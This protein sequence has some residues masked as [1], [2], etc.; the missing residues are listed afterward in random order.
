MITV[1]TPQADRSPMQQRV[2]RCATT[3]KWGQ[4]VSLAVRDLG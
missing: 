3:Q 2:N 1:L 4:T